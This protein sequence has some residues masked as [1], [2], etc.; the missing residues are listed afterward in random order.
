VYLVV[1][2]SLSP[3]GH[4]GHLNQYNRE[5]SVVEVIDV[6]EIKTDEVVVF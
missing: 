1:R 2:G 5:L 6:R 4:Y 3:V